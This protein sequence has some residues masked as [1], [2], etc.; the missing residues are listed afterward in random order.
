[1]PISEIGYSPEIRSL[2]LPERTGVEG[3]GASSFGEQFLKMIKDVDGE[4]KQAE[5]IAE[6]FAAG[7]HNNIHE[8]MLAA[9]RA[10]IAFRL[11]GSVRN[12]MIEA[13]QTV[14]RMNV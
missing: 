14:L 5:S 8:T 12:K 7:E 2:Q 6:A 3:P 10:T 4:M 11:V 13:Y 9:E 1:M